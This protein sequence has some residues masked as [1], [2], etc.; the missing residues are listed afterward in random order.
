M[1]STMTGTGVT[2]GGTG[3]EQ[4]SSLY[5]GNYGIGAIITG[6]YT[7][8]NGTTITGWGVGTGFAGSSIVADFMLLSVANYY[9]PQPPL[10][11][12]Q[13]DTRTAYQHSSI[14]N[15][16]TTFPASG[17]PGTYGCWYQ[18]VGSGSWMNLGW[19]GYNYASPTAGWTVTLFRRYA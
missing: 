8:S 14:F 2:Y 12:S 1:A 7:Y 4:Q 6:C 19:V 16:S 18:S 10:G 17:T 11:A 5:N 13:D 15:S 3:Y 9:I